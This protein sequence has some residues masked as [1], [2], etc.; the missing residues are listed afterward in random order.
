[1]ELQSSEHML[2]EE[3]IEEPACDYCHS[4]VIPPATAM[5][6]DVEELWQDEIEQELRETFDY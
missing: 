3:C 4:G 2:C 6:D 1:M 5:P